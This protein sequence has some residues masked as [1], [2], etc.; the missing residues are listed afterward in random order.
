MRKYINNTAVP[1]SLAVFLASDNYDHD[2]KVVSV[3]T[4]IKPIRQTVLAAR[5]PA[6]EALIDISGLVQSRVGSAV[7]DGIESSWVNNYKKAMSALGYPS[8]VIKRVLVNPSND[9]LFEGCIPVYLER[10]S[11]KEVMGVTVSGKFDFVGD[12][13]VEDFKNTTVF[14]WINSTKTDDYILQGSMYR[15]LNPDIITKDT[16]AIQFIFSDWQA[17]R[18][19]SDPGYPAN[20]TMQKVFQLMSI[21]ETEA[22]VRSRISLLTKYWN[23]PEGEVPRCTDDELWRSDPVFK[24][25]KNPSN[26]GRSTKNF[27]NKVDAYTRMGQDG[28]VGKVVEVPGQV[29]AC[30]YCSAFPVCSQKD[31]LIAAGDLIL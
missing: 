9:E 19:R 5:V 17:M 14:T 11:S 20:R 2:D 3:T 31:D 21:P 12:G 22:Y 26:T 6:E 7:H 28:N 15:W 24:Y 4:L 23:A 18:A 1:L 10:R 16:M 27:E 30:K 25:Y 13:Q 29:V 8:N